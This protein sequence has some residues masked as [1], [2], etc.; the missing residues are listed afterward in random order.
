[1]TMEKIKEALAALS[2]LT[3]SGPKADLIRSALEDAEQEAARYAEC[4]RLLLAA[5]RLYQDQALELERVQQETES[6]EAYGRAHEVLGPTI[7]FRKGKWH[8]HITENFASMCE[9]ASY[10]EVHSKLAKWCRAELAK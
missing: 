8:A 6:I 7:F 2:Y 1:M 9:G 3:F 5:Q 4:H 10:A